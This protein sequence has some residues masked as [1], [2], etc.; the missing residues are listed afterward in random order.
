MGHDF[1]AAFCLLHTH[2]AS[3]GEPQTSS[4][5][6]RRPQAEPEWTPL[7]SG[8]SCRRGRTHSTHHTATQ[9]DSS[10][11]AGEDRTLAHDLSSRPSRAVRTWSGTA[12]S[13][14]HPYAPVPHSPYDTL[15][16]VSS[17][18]KQGAWEQRG[19]SYHWAIRLPGLGAKEE[20][21][22]DKEGKGE[23]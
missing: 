13:P 11:S 12:R 14:S 16:K 19:L 22:G 3:I 4:S 15:I 17:S 21:K 7:S 9:T 10:Q 5:M 8:S 1:V 20:E 2:S 6:L 18:C 23:T